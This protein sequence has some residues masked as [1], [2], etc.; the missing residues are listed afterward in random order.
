VTPGFPDGI[1]VDA[2]GRV[3]VGVASGVQ[4]FNPSGDLIGEIRLA[5]AVNFT[6]GGPDNHILF[7]TADTA[8]WAA[9]LQARGAI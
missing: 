1:K 8:I 9:E 7:I 2:A 5:G 3:Y 4:V 6:F